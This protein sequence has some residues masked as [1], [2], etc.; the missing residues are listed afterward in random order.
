MN[1]TNVNKIRFIKYNYR[2]H[3]ASDLDEEFDPAE[4]KQR[5]IRI[6]SYTKYGPWLNLIETFLVIYP[7]RFLCQI[8]VNRELAKSTGIRKY[9]MEIQI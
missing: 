5:W 8:G 7:K 9:L 3:E 2:T 6:Y 1:A 4:T